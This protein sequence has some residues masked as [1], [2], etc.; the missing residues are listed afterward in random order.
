MR[1]IHSTAS[2]LAITAALGLAAGAQA[3]Q[4]VLKNGS[5]IVGKLV[6][7]TSDKVVY[8][9]PFAGQISIKQENI[10][11]ITTEEPV[12][13][14]MKNG[15]VY[16]GGYISTSEDEIMVRADGG[17]PVRIEPLDIEKVNPEPWEIGEGYKWSGRVMLAVE[18][19][20]GNSDSDEWA[21]DV[22]SVWRSLLDRYTLEGN[23]DYEENNGRRSENEWNLLAKYD[24]FLAGSRKNYRGFKTFFEHDEFAGL[25]LRTTV[26]PYIGRQFFDSD[27]LRLEA[28]LG[29]VYVDEDFAEAPDNN[30]WGASWIANA[31]SDVIGFDS[32]IYLKQDGTLNL[33]QTSDLIL[34]TKIG[35]RLPL[36]HGFET[37]FEV[38]YDYDGGAP[39]GVDELDRTYKWKLGYGW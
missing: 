3:D 12:T 27:R 13:L 9:T 2:V 7:S 1:L 5:V 6:S 36:L 29:P 32:R 17:A 31:E 35:V 39:D 19:E 37:A 16:Q 33:D 25:D 11:S 4:V 15:A 8:D 30:W 28:E 22:E 34:N 14:K 26:G 38:E 20:R 24:R 21:L 18:F 10:V 23:L